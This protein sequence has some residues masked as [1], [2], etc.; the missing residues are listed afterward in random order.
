MRINK[1]KKK[2]ISQGLEIEYLLVNF[3]KT[4]TN[5]EEILAVQA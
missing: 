1:V 2:F 5:P 3:C 4:A